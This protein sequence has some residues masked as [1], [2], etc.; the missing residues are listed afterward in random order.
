MSFIWTRWTRGTVNTWQMTEM[1]RWESEKLSWSVSE[2]VKAKKKCNLLFTTSSSWAECFNTFTAIT[3]LCLIDERNLEKRRCNIFFI[4]LYRYSQALKRKINRITSDCFF[5]YNSSRYL[6][7]PFCFFFFCFA[8]VIIY[9]G[10]EFLGWN[11]STISH[12]ILNRKR[13]AGW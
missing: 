8:V 4:F 11:S 3:N 7:A 1:K 6:Y 9:S 5:L 2:E 12:Q 10:K 13:C